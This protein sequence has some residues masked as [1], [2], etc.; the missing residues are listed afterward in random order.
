MWRPIAPFRPQHFE[1]TSIFPLGPGRNVS[2]R[3]HSSPFV[4]IFWIL[5][6]ISDSY[7]ATG[8]ATMQPAGDFS[9]V[10]ANLCDR[11]Q[12]QFTF[13]R[14]GDKERLGFLNKIIIMEYIPL[15]GIYQ[16]FLSI[17]IQIKNYAR[18]GSALEAKADLIH[19]SGKRSLVAISQ[20]T[21]LHL[22]THTYP[23]P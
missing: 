12:T 10:R 16:G 23:N 11:P 22:D 13:S 18:T 4:Y 15:L 21:L 19:P 2:K 20:H 14:A 6:F 1:I 5:V 9:T 7:T 17:Y 3:R 8:G